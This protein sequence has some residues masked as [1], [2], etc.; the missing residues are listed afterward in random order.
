[1][2]VFQAVD[3]KGNFVGSQTDIVLYTEVSDS[4]TAAIKNERYKFINGVMQEAC[5]VN[6][7]TG[8]IEDFKVIEADDKDRIYMPIP[9]HLDPI[10]EDA[11]VYHDNRLIVSLPIGRTIKLRRLL[12]RKAEEMKDL[13]SS[14]AINIYEET[15]YLSP[16]DKEY[17][18]RELAGYNEKMQ[19]LKKHIEEC[20]D[21]GT[22]KKIR[23]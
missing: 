8:Y 22:I 14:F 3:A 21:F 12:D 15:R 10:Y 9:T 4:D 11:F 23:W 6:T 16:E 2:R 20:D 13:F 5:V 19:N 17:I 18:D 7:A 1:M